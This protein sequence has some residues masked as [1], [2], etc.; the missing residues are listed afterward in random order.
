MKKTDVLVIPD[1][2]AAPGQD[3]S[4]FTAVGKLAHDMYFTS[5]ERGRDFV[6][7]QL[8][9]FGELSSTSSYEKADAPTYLEDIAACREARALIDAEVEGLRMR[10]VA[11]GG[12]HENPR[13]KRKETA[14]PSLKGLMNPM[15]D[16]GWA[17]A[18]WEVIPFKEIFM[19]DQVGFTHYLTSGVMDRPIG[20]VNMAR[21][22][23]LKGTM[24]MIVGHSHVL[25]H[26][27]LARA[28]GSRITAISAGLFCDPKEACFSWNGGSRHY[29]AGIVKLEGLQGSDFDFTAMR[30]DTLMELY[31]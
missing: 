19:L 25:D 31:G 3:L 7:I 18:G 6:L 29:W 26:S 28:D 22:I 20:G 11:L 27:T 4:R 5:L 10:K 13:V 14:D 15:E 1:A 8:G 17:E 12:N 30:L 24:S 2:H 21:N 9:D 16:I 23:L